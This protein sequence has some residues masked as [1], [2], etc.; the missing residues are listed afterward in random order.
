MRFNLIKL[1]LQREN[2]IKYI[3]WTKLTSIFKKVNYLKLFAIISKLILSKIVDI[4]LKIMYNYIDFRVIILFINDGIRMFFVVVTLRN[5][6]YTWNTLL[7]YYFLFSNLF[8]KCYTNLNW[9]LLILPLKKNKIENT[10]II[11]QK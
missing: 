11:K 3:F 2:C 6:F 5:L 8:F 4:Y 9:F 10:E 7:L 1:D